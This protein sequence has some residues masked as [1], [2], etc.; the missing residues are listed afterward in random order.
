LSTDA[1]TILE[2][3]LIGDAIRLTTEKILKRLTVD[4]A[5]GPFLGMIS[6]E[7][8]LRSGFSIWNSFAGVKS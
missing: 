5:A 1:I 7:S 2:E 4:D 8:P 6:R 3:V